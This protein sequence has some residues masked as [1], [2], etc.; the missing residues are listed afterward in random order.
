M[1]KFEADN[2]QEKQKKKWKEMMAIHR[3]ADVYPQYHFPSPYCR[4]AYI[5]IVACYE[6]VGLYI[7]LTEIFVLHKT[8]VQ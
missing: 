5:F 8:R 2:K 1:P 7:Y 6:Y 3:V 4:T